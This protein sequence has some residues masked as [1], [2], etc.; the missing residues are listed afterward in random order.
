M[1]LDPLGFRP[2]TAASARGARGARDRRRRWMVC[3]IAA[4]ALLLASAGGR[5]VT[6]AAILRLRCT[7]PASGASWPIVV[8][9]DRGL[10]DSRSATITD[11]WIRWQDPK[12][13]FFDLDRATGKLQFRNASSTGGYFLYYTCRPE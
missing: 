2:A 13:G 7:N 12:Q 5:G 6:A 11:Q 1:M 9:L 8:D 10:V 4:S 3:A